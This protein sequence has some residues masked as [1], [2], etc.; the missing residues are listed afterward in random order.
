MRVNHDGLPIGTLQPREDGLCL[1]YDDAKSMPYVWNVMSG[2]FIDCP[3][4]YTIL[5]L[6]L[7]Q[8]HASGRIFCTVVTFFTV[9]DRA[10]QMLLS[11]KR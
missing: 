10:V 1:M 4:G 2:Q 5:Q 6:E 3:V 11:E 8:F 7:C 9:L